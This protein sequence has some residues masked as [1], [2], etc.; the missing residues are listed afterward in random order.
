MRLFRTINESLV[1][2]KNIFVLRAEV[3]N[4]KLKTV[5]NIETLTLFESVVDVEVCQVVTV[6]VCEP[7]LGL[8]CL[9]FHLAR[10]YEALWY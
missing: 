9:F 1:L 3:E 8:V 7:H 5:L 6:D 4:E 10:S 2:V